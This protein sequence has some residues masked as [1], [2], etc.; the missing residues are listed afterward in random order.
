[1][2]KWAQAHENQAKAALQFSD[3]E[4]LFNNSMARGD[5]ADYTVPE[6]DQFVASQAGGPLDTSTS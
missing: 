5:K 6:L 2:Q 3:V 1:L 4:M